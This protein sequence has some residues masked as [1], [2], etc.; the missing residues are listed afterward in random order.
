MGINDFYEIIKVELIY[1]Q[2]KD[3]KKKKIEF[4]VKKK[5]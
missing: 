4:F 1:I 3:E 5:L 2:Y